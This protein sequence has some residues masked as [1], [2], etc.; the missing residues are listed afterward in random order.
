MPVYGH[1]QMPACVLLYMI[2]S[3]VKHST[4]KGS[5]TITTTERTLGTAPSLK[6]SQAMLNLGHS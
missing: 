5:G 2:I 6:D 1:M 4:G 3:Q